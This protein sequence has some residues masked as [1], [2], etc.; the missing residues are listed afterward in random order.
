LVKNSLPFTLDF[1]SGFAFSIL[2][3]YTFFW[4]LDHMTNIKFKN[5]LSINQKTCI[6]SVLIHIVGIIM[7]EKVMKDTKFW[8]HKYV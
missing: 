2:V 1:G 7:S 5:F 4:N 3:I 8:M 6:Q